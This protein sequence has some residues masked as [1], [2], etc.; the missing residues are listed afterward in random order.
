[1][2][3]KIYLGVGFLAAAAMVLPTFGSNM[4]EGMLAD[5]ETGFTVTKVCL[6]NIAGGYGN[7]ISLELNGFSSGYWNQPTISGGSVTLK[8][9][10]GES[11]TPVVECVG[12]QMCINRNGITPADTAGWIL[13][14]DQGTVFDFSGTAFILT[15]GIE[16]INKSTTGEYSIAWV[17]VPDIT[18]GADESITVEAN[19]TAKISA[20][21]TGDE[22][23]L[24][25]YKSADESIATVAADGT[26]TGLAEGSTTVTVYCDGKSK[27]VPVT[28]EASQAQQDAIAVTPKE[29]TTYVG[30]DYKV[31]E[32]SYAD[33]YAGVA[34]LSHEV[35]SDMISG[36]FDKDTI[37]DYTLTVTASGFSDTFVVHVVAIPEAT[38]TNDFG[39]GDG[40]GENFYF[41]TTIPDIGHYVTLSGDALN[42][43]AGHV[44]I[45]GAAAEITSV[46]NLGGGR[47]EFFWNNQLKAGDVITIKA[48]MYIWHYD[49]T[50]SNFAPQGDGEFVP[51]GEIKVDNKFV[52]T[53]SGW[54]GYVGEPESLEVSSSEFVSIG[55]TTQISATLSPAGTYGFV[56][57]ESNHTDIA[58]VDAN[59]LVTGVAEGEVT[60]TVKCGELTKQVTITVLPAS[61]IVGV[62]FA[63]I[64]NYFSILKDSNANDIL[65][66]VTKAKFVFQNE[67]KSGEFDI[68]GSTLAFV[69][70]VDTSELTDIEE[71]DVKLTYE[72]V[73][74][75]GKLPIKVYEP[76]AAEVKEVAVV[77]WFA[78]NLF[79]QMPA[80]NANGANMTGGEGTPTFSD[81]ISK[82]HYTRKDGTPVSFGIW[83][84][85]EQYCLLPQFENMAGITEDNFNDPELNYY[86]EGD[87]ITIEQGTPVYMW[88]GDIADKGGN[89]TPILGTG[90][91]IVASYFAEEM[92]F[93]FDGT[94][95]YRY[96]AYTDIAVDSNELT[97][98]VGE[99]TPV[100]AKRVPDNATSGKFTYSSSNESVVTVSQ[101]G[102]INAV[103]IGTATVTVTLAEEGRESKTATV[104]VTVIDAITDIEIS[105]TLQVEVGTESL[106]LTKLSA[107]TVW[108]SGK[109]GSAVDLKDAT[110]SGY[111]KD[112]LGAQQILVKIV[113]DGQTFSKKVTINVV[114]K[115]AEKEGG[116]GG[117]II[118]SSV[119]VS[120]FAL[121]GAIILKKKKEDK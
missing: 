76:I 113:V 97:L 13:S 59:G 38:I 55:G 20:T 47:Y 86:L 14:I 70:P 118:A 56:E 93:K 11:V 10:F 28:V 99:T 109:E 22:S 54:A 31:G 67:T 9:Q 87:T 102:V 46:I 19:A 90:E 52:W 29:L 8:N 57:Y 64:P 114:E 115:A 71:Y 32:L 98:K 74:Y 88:T 34:G 7:G 24:F 117:S 2:K 106:D 80:T 62:E 82:I 116:C 12:S 44:L 119:L 60:I 58:T 3:K 4:A 83:E 26:V 33:M 61:P 41:V 84:L 91:F 85:A 120:S 5:G 101:S 103:G 65:P 43:V 108:A 66:R 72:G 104:T 35:T 40:W 77:G 30:F 51:V 121:A 75:N 23:A 81:V 50:V 42:N 111:N 27:S 37:G 68:S 107:K 79:I 17:N 53:G 94:T 45:N 1:M 96:I 73:D 110:Y 112:K 100:G 105:G 15:E 39:M 78:C 92:V 36:T 6:Q 69:N 95:W 63:G 48:G 49:G 16:V 25:F 21:A 18:L 89:S